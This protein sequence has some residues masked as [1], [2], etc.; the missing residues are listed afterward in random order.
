LVP[1]SK[2]LPHHIT[3]LKV[4][5]ESKEFITIA[6]NPK[7][8][9]RCLEEAIGFP[10]VDIALVGEISLLLKSARFGDIDESLPA[11]FAEISDRFASPVIFKDLVSRCGSREED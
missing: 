7:H 6:R 1:T 10:P 4:R 11:G 9:M 5:V 3:L 8:R 2:D